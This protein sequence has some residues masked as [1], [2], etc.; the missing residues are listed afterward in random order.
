MRK[1]DLFSTCVILEFLGGF[2]ERPKILTQ[3]MAIFDNIIHKVRAPKFLQIVSGELGKDVS[4]FSLSLEY[5]FFSFV[6]FCCLIMH[7]W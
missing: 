4:A 2:G 7:W 6:S 3:Y 1:R 5:I